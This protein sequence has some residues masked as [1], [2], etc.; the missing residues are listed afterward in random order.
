MNTGIGTIIYPV[1]DVVKAKTRFS[2]LLG[3]EPY[4]EDAYYIGYKVGEQEI[5]LDPHGHMQGMTGPIGYFHVDDIEKSKQI[6]LEAGGEVLRDVMDV[7]AGKLVTTVKDVEGNVI[8]L[9]QLP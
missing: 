7:G 9:I 1:K 8:G 2:T 6:L 4:A 5:G 3:V